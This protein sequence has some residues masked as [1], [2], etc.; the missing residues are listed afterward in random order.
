L[1]PAIITGYLL[2]PFYSIGLTHLLHLR[3][4]HWSGLSRLGWKKIL[5]LIFAIAGIGLAQTLLIAAVDLAFEG[6]NSLFY[7]PEPLLYTALGTTAATAMWGFLY[8]VR[9]TREQRARL[10]LALREAELRALEGQINPH[11]LFNCLN[12]IRALVAEDPAKAQ[13]MITRLANIFRYN[14]HRDSAHT[15]PLAS[16]VE[17]VSDYLALEAARFEER[18]QVKVEIAPEAC[19]ARVPPMLLQTLVENALKHGIAPLASGGDLLIRAERTLGAVRIQVENPGQLGS[20]DNDA[21][22]PGGLGLANTRERLRLLYGGRASL[23][24]ED[25][26]NGRVIATVLIPA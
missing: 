14:L 12:S 22:E 1:S 13:D 10:R 11:F 5:Q 25:S 9:R 6:K 15:V 8:W 19:Q 7:Q 4:R 24:L 3:I 23:H 2:Y 20:G 21:A 16:E 18:L 17:V 26:P